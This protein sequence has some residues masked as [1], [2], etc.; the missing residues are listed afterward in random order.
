MFNFPQ[1]ER[2]GIKC[3]WV[4]QS[5]RNTPDLSYL[6]AVDTCASVDFKEFPCVPERKCFVFLP[7][8]FQNQVETPVAQSAVSRNLLI[9]RRTQLVVKYSLDDAEFYPKELFD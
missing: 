7:T 2:R 4:Q 6:T 1:Q 9:V 5:Q 8:K 3:V